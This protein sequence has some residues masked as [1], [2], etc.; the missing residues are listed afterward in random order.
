[1][2]SISEDRVEYES[3]MIMRDVI[4]KIASKNEASMGN[5]ENE[6]NHINKST[7]D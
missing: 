2:N 5:Q 4:V 7:N 1:M 6:I 3:S